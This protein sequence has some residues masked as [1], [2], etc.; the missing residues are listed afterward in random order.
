MRI[1]SASLSPNTD[2][3]D[4]LQSLFMLFTPWRWHHGSYLEQIQEWFSKRFVGF[5]GFPV[6]SG[7]GALYLLLTSFGV[8]RGD[9]VL[10]QSFTCVAVPNSVLWT[11][12][13][14]IYIDIDSSL[15][16]DVNDAKKRSRNTQ[17]H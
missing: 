15:N 3:N 1:T 6:N 5:Y 10:V 13:K 14:P 16:L 17:R 11:G 9:E 8:G 2:A 12:A 4:T 7:R